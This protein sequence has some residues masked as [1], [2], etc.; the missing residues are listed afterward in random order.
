M[1]NNKQIIEVLVA[2][3]NK[4]VANLTETSQKLKDVFGK[5]NAVEESSK[6]FKEWYA[7]QEEITKELVAAIKDQVITEQT[8]SFVKEW[9]ETQENFGKKWMEAIQNS[10]AGFSTEKTFDSYKENVNKVYDM[11]KKSYDQFAGMFSTSFGVQKYDLATQAKEMHDN[12]VENAQ[13]H[14]K[15]LESQV[16]QKA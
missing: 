15:S 10:S 6:V 14:L 3:Q 12:F 16:L 5:T 4:S 2:V 13:K 8:P 7:K 9:M 11:W 1:S